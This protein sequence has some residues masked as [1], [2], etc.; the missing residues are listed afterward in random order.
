[1]DSLDFSVIWARREALWDG[2]MLTAQLTTYAAAIGIVAGAILAAGST[3]G[4]KWLKAIIRVYVDLIRGLPSIL[5][6]FWIFFL[7]PLILGRP[8][9]AL[10][11]GVTTFAFIEAGYACEIFRTGIGGVNQ[12]QWQAGLSCGMNRPKVFRFIILPQALRIVRPL[13]VTQVI[14]IFQDVSLVYVVALQDFVTSASIVAQSEQRLV[15]IYL[16]VAL[17]YAVI[18]IAGSRLVKRMSANNAG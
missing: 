15:E 6:I 17:V 14:L 4:P 7:I 11:A 8:I 9:S 12:G 3:F 18:C 2:F 16:F 10:V 13:L 1:M 5:L